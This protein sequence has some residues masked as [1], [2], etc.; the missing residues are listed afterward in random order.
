VI[1][2]AKADHRMDRNHPAGHQGCAANAVL[3]AAG[4]SFSLL[5]SWLS[6]LIAH[7]FQVLL[8]RDRMIRSAVST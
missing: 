8:D 1:G 6:R 4:F 2:H 5:I 3:A 7:L